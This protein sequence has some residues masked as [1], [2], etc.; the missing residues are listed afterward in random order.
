M[1]AIRQNFIV[2]RAI[3]SSY[4]E[5]ALVHVFLYDHKERE[6]R[7]RGEGEKS[8]GGVVERDSDLVYFPRI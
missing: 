8:V 1:R 7:E 4:I 2:Q 6:R 5:G 3:R